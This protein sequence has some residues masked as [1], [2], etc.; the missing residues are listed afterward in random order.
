MSI[1]YAVLAALFIGVLLGSMLERIL[2]DI[3]GASRP[4]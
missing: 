2:H 3:N 1:N 4:H